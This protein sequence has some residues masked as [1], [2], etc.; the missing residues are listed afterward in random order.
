MHK[1]GDFFVTRSLQKLQGN[2][3]NEDIDTN[4]S[5]HPQL[6]YMYI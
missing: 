1:F 3:K 5:N 6:H 2:E 4:Y